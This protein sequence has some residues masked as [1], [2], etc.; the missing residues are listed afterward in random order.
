MFKGVKETHWCKKD[1][2]IRLGISDKKYLQTPHR[3]AGV[4][5][6]LVCDR[7]RLLVR[8]WY[9]TACDYHMIDDTPSMGGDPENFVEHR[10]DQSIFSLL[11]K[12][13][14]FHSKRSMYSCVDCARNTTDISVIYKNCPSS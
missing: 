9:E 6:L 13:H 7:T 11:T 1:L 3:E 5:A 10:H 8:E 4:I 14:N 12:K 2:M